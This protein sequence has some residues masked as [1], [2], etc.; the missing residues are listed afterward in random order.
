V[1]P[2]DPVFLGL[3]ADDWQAIWLGVRISTLAVA[4]SLPAGI[5]LAWVLARKDFA[6]KAAVETVVNLPLVLPPVVTGLLL[7]YA[8]GP[9]STLGGWFRGAFGID[10]A[11]TWRAA[12][13]AVGVVG[14]PLLVRSVRIA[15]EGV[16]PRLHDAARSLG[17][18]PFDA[19]RTVSLPLALNGVIAGTVLSFARGLG[20]FGATMMFASIRPE[21]TTLAIQVYV[22]HNQPGDASEQRMWRIVVAS[23]LLAFTALAASEVLV[24]RARRDERA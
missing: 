22:L 5:A 7:L 2:A 3:A 11:F 15:F 4:L 14:F 18:G 21:T 23:V 1:S 8:L 20:E 6:G 24:R 19:F 12:V 9:R 13:L 10:V 16:D 17:A